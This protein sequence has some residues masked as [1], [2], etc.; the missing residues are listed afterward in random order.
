MYEETY[1]QTYRGVPVVATWRF[2]RTL[3]GRQLYV[4]VAECTER[5]GGGFVLY[6]HTDSRTP[7]HI[8]KLEWIFRRVQLLA[9]RTLPFS[10]RRSNF[11]HGYWP[12]DEYLRQ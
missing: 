12:R 5:G 8:C 6:K 7:M 10:F 2:P 4:E 3:G 1:A 9:I 11:S